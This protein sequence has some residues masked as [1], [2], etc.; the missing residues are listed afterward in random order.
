MASI[1]KTENGYLAQ[2]RSKGVNKSKRFRL[3]TEAT[4]WAAKIEAD[5]AAHAR[6]ELPNYTLNEALVKYQSEVTP[7]HRAYKSETVHLNIIMRSCLPVN[8]ALHLI[9]SSDIAAWRDWRSKQVSDSTVNREMTIIKSVFSVA[10]R[11][12][13]WIRENPCLTVSKKPHPKHRD[14]LIT[15]AERD[16]ILHQLHGERFGLRNQTRAAFELALETGMRLGEIVGLGVSDIV[17]RV[18]RL[19]LTKNGNARDVPLSKRALEI[20]DDIEHDGQLFTMQ[21]ASLSRAFTKAV[22]RA[23]INDL[24]FHDSRH[25]A[26]TM[27][28]KKLNVLELA[29]SIGHRD[30]KSLMTYYNETAENLA[31]KLD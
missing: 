21:P 28:A 1:T 27:L 26:I 30:L 10:L 23:K 31:S 12:W 16:A 2:V 17:G 20:I 11:E 8:R 13:G 4:L 9:A 19:E 24:H 6:G 29:R 5:L 14:R 15:D 7:N 22:Q 25:A 18:A 3:K